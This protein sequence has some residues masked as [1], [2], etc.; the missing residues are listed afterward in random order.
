[1]RELIKKFQKSLLLLFIVFN[2]GLYLLFSVCENNINMKQ[3]SEPAII[4]FF[5]AF[6]IT[7][8]G[9]LF[10]YILSIIEE[11]DEKINW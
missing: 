4:I 7:L 2:V 8:I 3:W 1:M 5:I 11:A 10:M 9:F 6:G